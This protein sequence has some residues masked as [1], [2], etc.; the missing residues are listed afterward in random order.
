MDEPTQPAA[1]PGTDLSL[2]G[3]EHVRLYR[4]TNGETGYLWNGVPTL[5]LTTTGRR[6][7]EPRTIPIIFTPHGD[8]YVIIASK[9]GAPTHPKWYLNV[10]ADPH[11]QVQV[12]ADRFDAVARTAEPP[13]RERLW[14]EAV[15]A[16]P[17]YDIYQSRTSRRIPVVVLERRS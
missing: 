15:K 1:V 4:E 3:A 12:K 10:E 11:V 17:N 5:L 14:R 16:W 8:S 2:L 7:G 13:E 6:S 9:G